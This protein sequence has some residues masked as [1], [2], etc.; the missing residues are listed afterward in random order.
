V[1]ARLLAVAALLCAAGVAHAQK[2][3]R[4]IGTTQL[5]LAIDNCP[6]KDPTLTSEQLVQRASETFDRGETLYAQGDYDGAVQ[7]LIASYCLIPSCATLK[8]AGQAFE[9]ELDYEQAIGY[10]NRYVATL[11]EGTPR[12][13]DCLED[14]RHPAK[15]RDLI[16][17]RA[18]TLA[19]LKAH[20]FVETE[21]PGARI[22]IGNDAGIAARARAGEP[23]EVLGGHYTMTVE[24]DGYNPSKQPL[25]L[26]V[27]KPYAY[28]VKLAAQRGRLSVQAQPADARIF[29]ADRF[30]GVGHV[31]LPLDASPYTVVIEAPDRVSDRR[32]VDVLPDQVQRV[33]VELE[34][35]PQLGRTQLIIASGAEGA[36]AGGGLLYA[37]KQSGIT[38][39]GVGVGAV[40]GLAGSYFYLPHDLPLGTSNLTITTTIAGYAFGAGTALLFTKDEAGI[41]PIAAASSLLGGAVGYY[42]GLRTKVNTGDAALVNSGVMWGTATGILFATAFDPPHLVTGGLVLT[43]LGA[44]TVGALLLSR[45]YNLSR[46]HVLLIDVGGLVGVAG[47]L[48][49]E[50]LAYPTQKVMTN[51]TNVD[52]RTREHLSNF[53]LGGMAVGLIAA[54]ILTRN[55]DNPKVP[56]GAAT[57]KPAHALITPSVGQAVL[58]SGESVATFGVAGAW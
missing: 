14:P 52:T 54:G 35:K 27:G 4:Y 32:V 23:I 16:A 3:V 39:I 34:R 55:Y 58:P 29:I 36:L 22:T 12:D 37:F 26:K 57:P 11:P 53:A 2:S 47:G 40:A 28:F 31:D 19:T 44:G 49:V 8:D 15:D 43:G 50:S 9:R 38:G 45:E 20:V 21:P 42:A 5:R 33:S 1:I 25:D 30:A 48:A 24:R 41:Q 46:T 7:E 17:H 6:A 18:E 13:G 51:A 56:V 10:L